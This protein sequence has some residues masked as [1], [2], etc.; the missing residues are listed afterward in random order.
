MQTFDDEENDGIAPL[1]FFETFFN[2]LL[3]PAFRFEIYFYCFVFSCSVCAREG[4]E[5]V[6]QTAT[7]KR[8]IY[9]SG[10]VQN[11]LTDLNY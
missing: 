4:G 3:W 10:N 6:P 8:K 2:Y 1:K 7:L 9:S 5:G 11:F